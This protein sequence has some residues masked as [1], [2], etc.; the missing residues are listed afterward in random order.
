MMRFSQLELRFSHTFAF[1]SLP[2]FA[3][4]GAARGVPHFESMLVAG[5]LKTSMFSGFASLWKVERCKVGHRSVPH[6]P[7]CLTPFRVRQS[8]AAAQRMISNPPVQSPNN[9]LAQPSL[10]RPLEIGLKHG[11]PR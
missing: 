6:C 4:G 9:Y 5:V 11:R 1:F 8:G 10:T 3:N 7:T 2:H